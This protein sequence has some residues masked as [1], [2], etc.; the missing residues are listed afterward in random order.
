MPD[1]TLKTLFDAMHHGKYDFA[2]F[3]HADIEPNYEVVALKNRV[4]Y[5][6]NKK[7][8]AYHKFINTFI[9]N[10]L[11]INDRICHSYRK[12]FSAL[13]AVSAHAKNRAFF[14]TD[15]NNFFASI[16]RGL[17]SATLAN[18]SMRVPVA[19]FHDHI[20]RIVNLVTAGNSL[21]IGFATSP[22]ISNSCLTGFDN[23]LESHC[24]NITL[25]YTR[26]SDDIVISGRSRDD[27]LSINATV[28]DLLERHF[29]GT[30]ALN[31]QKSKLTTIGRKI[32]ILGMVIL[33][34][35]RVTLDRELKSRIEVLIHFYVTDREKFLRLV[36]NDL[37]GG[38]EQ[39]SGYINHVNAIDKTYLDK[40]QT[41]FG[42]AVID[43]F[44]HKSAT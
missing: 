22:S 5:Q 33:P 34:S 26:Y 25:T 38:I 43:S 28:A 39:L 7:L 23:D 2:D 6:P 3:M 1:K 13:T 24:H 12:G 35:G 44:A 30:L 40:L 16:S 29:S 41:K 8:R 36:D 15:I 31:I 17:V 37:K 11:E 42:A 21:P 9:C 10:Y 20:D 32:K 18:R 19:D 4:V 14:Q 27:L